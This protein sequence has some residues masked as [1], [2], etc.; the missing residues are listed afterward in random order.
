MHD[1]SNNQPANPTVSP[2][3]HPPSSQTPVKPN[4]SPVARMMSHNLDALLIFMCF[5]RFSNISC[6]LVY[7]NP[8]SVLCRLIGTC[9][10][11]FNNLQP[12]GLPQS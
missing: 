1:A 5:E 9:V 10:I 8:K 6:G 4:T 7:D 2:M 3:F 12:R 11:S